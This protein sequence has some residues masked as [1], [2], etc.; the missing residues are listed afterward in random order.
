MTWKQD[1]D[2]ILQEFARVPNVA[3]YLPDHYL[4]L[5]TKCLIFVNGDFIYRDGVHLRRNLSEATKNALVKILHLG[6]LFSANPD[7]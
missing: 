3:V 2:H 6:D 5:P 7:D 4:C 1:V